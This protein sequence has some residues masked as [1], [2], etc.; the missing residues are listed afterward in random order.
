MKESKK[1][2]EGGLGDLQGASKDIEDVINDCQKRIYNQ[3][4]NQ[5]QRRILS[6]MLDSQKSMTQRGYKEERKAFIAYTCNRVYLTF[7]FH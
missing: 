1:S 5:K 2:G 3:Q 7:I 4:T 6:R